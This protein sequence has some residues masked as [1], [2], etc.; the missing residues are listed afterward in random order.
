[1]PIPISFVVKS[2][3]DFEDAA[4]M[5]GLGYTDMLEDYDEEEKAAKEKAA[6]ENEGTE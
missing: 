6:L 2:A 4:V 1:M 3:R 5:A